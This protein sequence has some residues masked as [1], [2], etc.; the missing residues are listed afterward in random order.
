MKKLIS[1]IACGE[2]LNEYE[3]EEDFQREILS[4]GF[5]GI[6][7]VRCLCPLEKIDLNMVK[8]VHLPFYTDWID[9]NYGREDYVLREFGH[10]ETARRFYHFKPGEYWKYFLKDLELAESFGEYTVFHVANSGIKEYINRDFHLSDR[11]IIDCSLE[12]INRL[13]SGREGK[14]LFLMENLYFPGLTLTDPHLSDYLL[15][16]VD[17]EN[18]GFMLDTGH[19]MCTNTGLSSEDEAWDYAEEIVKKHGSLKKYFKGIHLHISMTGKVQEYL[20]ENPPVLADNFLERFSQI[21]EYS[22]KIDTHSPVSSYKARKF[23]DFVAP[24]YLV[25]EFKYANR[26]EMHDKSLK[27]LKILNYL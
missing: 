22:A 12:I 20:K 25:L 6:E 11:E 1:F 8:G 21:Y 24:E 9:Y 19:L 26:K 27:Q 7:L 17:Y 5:D 18:K 13:L 14:N 23:I 15:S 3:S 16:G 4:L 2:Y 10:L